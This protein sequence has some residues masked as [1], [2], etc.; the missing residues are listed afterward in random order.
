MTP[1]YFLGVFIII[2]LIIQGEKMHL[3]LIITILGKDRTGIVSSISEILEQHQSSWSESRISHLAGKIAGIL[4]VSVP[5]NRV[6]ELT[7]A[8]D[9]FQSDDLKITIETAA[10]EL[11]TTATKT[12]HVELLCQ[13]RIGIVHDVTERLAKLNVN[14]E[15]LDSHLK[16]ASMAGGMLFSAELTLGLP[17]NV[18]ADAVEDC[19]EE[20]SDQFMIDINLS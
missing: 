18:D 14:I 1:P 12:I 7:V 2:V 19:L 17:D 3:S 16:E 8:L 20:M 15:E 10:T 11:K 13:D 4:Q 9:D 6:E 5:D